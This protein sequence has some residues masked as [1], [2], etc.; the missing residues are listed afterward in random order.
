VQAD[1]EEGK[2]N[3]DEVTQEIFAEVLPDLKA[4]YAGLELARSGRQKDMQDFASFL[5]VGFA[6]AL[7]VMYLLLAV[8]LRSY[9]Q[10][11]LV[12]MMA[13]PFGFTGALLGHLFMGMPMSMVSMMG[14]VALSGV[15]VND[16]LVL[17]AAA[18]RFRRE[19]GQDRFTAAMSAAHQRFRPVILT[20][21]TT[22][23]GL[24]PMIF[25]TSVQARV[26][27]PMAV[28]LGFGVLFSTLVVLL[29]VPT[30]FAMVEGLR[31]WA[32][33]VLPWLE[34]SDDLVASETQVAAGETR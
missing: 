32:G 28:S 3:P 21:L 26:L 6:L 24:A 16:S 9:L 1:V 27:V 29:L 14:M 11:F 13:I 34:G 15:V 18:N 4:R 22:F 31:E 10:P 5:K 8:P 12:V 19:H 7:L 20:S 17:V 33:R 25:E 23:G 30:L 2:A